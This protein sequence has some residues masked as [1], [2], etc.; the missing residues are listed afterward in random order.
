MTKHRLIY[1]S[2]NIKKPIYYA[3]LLEQVARSEATSIAWIVNKQRTSDAKRAASTGYGECQT[4]PIT[5]L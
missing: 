1:Q 4:E 2:N 3:E 5:L